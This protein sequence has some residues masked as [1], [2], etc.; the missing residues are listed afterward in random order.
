V[1]EELVVRSYDR[2]MQMAKTHRF[3]SGGRF[4]PQDAEEAGHEAF[5]RVSAMAAKF[6]GHSAGEFRATV[7]QT[8]WN[9]CMDYGRE[10]LR[11]ERHRGGSL[12]EAAF[13]EQEGARGRYDA[14]V[15]AESVSREEEAVE[16]AAAEEARA[17]RTE[18]L[19]RAIAMVDN[20]GHRDV[21]RMTYLHPLPAEAIAEQLGIS[22]DNVYQRRRR[23]KQALD[24]ILR[25]L[26][27]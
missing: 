8:V 20:E 9:A 26:R 16:A 1:W 13:G 12:D 11:H 6:R 27:D 5:L 2:V 3:P 14:V 17:E 10:Q 15:A 18:L 4:S 24:R 21:L 7:R 19:R 23:G 22:L 25:E